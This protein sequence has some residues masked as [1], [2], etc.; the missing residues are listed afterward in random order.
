[1]EEQPQHWPRLRMPRQENQG[2]GTTWG[3]SHAQKQGT[4]WENWASTT[5][6]QKIQKAMEK[7]STCPQ[8]LTGVASSS[9]AAEKGMIKAGDVL[10][11]SYTSK[12]ATAP[13]IPNTS[14]STNRITTIL[15]PDN[16]LMSNIMHCDKMAG[17]RFFGHHSVQECSIKILLDGTGNAGWSVW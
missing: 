5:L 10:F 8:Q 11:N 7:N 15:K 13:F 2:W 1:M 16:H 3:R 12:S 14:K 6:T 17:W 4:W 9:A